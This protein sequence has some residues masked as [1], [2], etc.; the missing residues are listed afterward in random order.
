MERRDIEIFLTLAEETHFGR[1]AERLHVTTARVSQTISKLERAIGTSLFH[2]TS[3]RVELTAVGMQLEAD[4]RPA[5]E[6]IA[7]GI[8]RAIAAGRG[9]GGLLRV[10]YLGPEAGRICFEAAAALTERFPDC[11][12]RVLEVQNGQGVAPLR[13]DEADVLFLCFP[14]H[15]PDLTCGPV[16]I[17]EPRILVVSSRHPFARRPSISLED[18]SRDKVISVR[19]SPGIPEYYWHESRLPDRTPGGRPIVRGP[20]AST[21]QE[22]LALAGAGQGML[23]AGAQT[24]RYF[25]R[26]DVAYLPFDDAPPVEWGLVW[27]S[28]NETPLVRAFGET[29]ARIARATAAQS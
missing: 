26:P 9:M 8:E 14:F 7:Q 19:P 1:T 11:E 15:E 27:R 23:V 5:M 25:P 2:R 6:Q 10:G 12:V 18:L 20:T 22:M 29:A 24:A 3:R 16:L 17:S 13:M 28:A 4:L 21:F